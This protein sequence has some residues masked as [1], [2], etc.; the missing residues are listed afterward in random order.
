[1]EQKAKRIGKLNIIDLIAIVLIVAV[2]ALAA[3]KFIGKNG[4][5]ISYDRPQTKVTYQVKVEGVAPELYENCQAHLPS[6]LMASGALV[7]GQ[8]EAVEKETYQVLD[9]NGNWVTDPDHVTLIFTVT[10]TTPTAEVMTT[11]VGDQEVRIGK[12]VYSLG[13][14]V[15][16]DED[17]LLARF[18]FFDEFRCFHL[19]GIKNVLGF[20][21]DF[22]GSASDS[23]YTELLFDIGIGQSA[24]D[25]IRIRVLMTRY[26]RHVFHE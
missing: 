4:D 24:A 17:K 3:W 11:K 5:G 6:P 26:N 10:T 14:F 18:D 7:G 21:A 25:G 1:M 19:E 16:V 8:I 23:R 2:L 13:F 9:A 22:A 20:L 12:T 15:M